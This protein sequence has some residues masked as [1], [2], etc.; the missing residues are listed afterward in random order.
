M[1]IRKSFFLKAV[2]KH[3]QIKIKM[4]Y[5]IVQNFYLENW[6][7]LDNNFK[8]YMDFF[9]MINPQ[10]FCWPVYEKFQVYVKSYSLSHFVFRKWQNFKFHLFLVNTYL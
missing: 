2:L 3:H 6:N 7:L 8:K 1:E 9:L 5:I 4:C 10:R